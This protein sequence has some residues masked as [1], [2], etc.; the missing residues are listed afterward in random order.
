MFPDDKAVQMLL[1]F[2]LSS[3]HE[4][5][6]IAISGLEMSNLFSF[7]SFFFFH[8]FLIHFVSR[9]FMAVIQ[10]IRSLYSVLEKRPCSWTLLFKVFYESNWT[11]APST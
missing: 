7:L 4:K 1:S 8:F 10:L 6:H 2:K 3:H 9:R 5:Y 11:G